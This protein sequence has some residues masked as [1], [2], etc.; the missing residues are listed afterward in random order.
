V[1]IVRGC[2]FPDELFYDVERHVWYAPAEGGLVRAGITQVGVA[3]AHEVIVLTPKQTGTS[4]EKGRALATV[5]SAKWVGS[6]RSAF[7]GA[8]A[9]INEEAR[10]NPALVNEDCYGKGWVMLIKPSNADWRA[11][12]VTGHAIAAAYE[13]WMESEAWPG[14][15]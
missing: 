3:L 4:F 9:S 15:G 7:D 13:A 14:C 12:L 6:V 8:V 1:A 10:R 2:N 11:G 5:E